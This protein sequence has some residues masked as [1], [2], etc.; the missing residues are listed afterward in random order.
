MNLIQAVGSNAKSLEEFQGVFNSTFALN[1]LNTKY[2]IYNPDAP[3]LVNQKALGNAWF[4]EK[5]VIVENAN[6]EISSL[7]YF[8]PAKE[9]LIDN[10]IQGSD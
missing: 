6:K 9:A 5:P 1:M 10:V 7:N 8:N 4:V 2:V 3:P